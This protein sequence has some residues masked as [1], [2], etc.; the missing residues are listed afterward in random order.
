MAQVTAT[1]L[2]GPRTVFFAS[3]V[4]GTMNVNV[5]LIN[6]IQHRIQTTNLKAGEMTWREIE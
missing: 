3:L 1:G 2:E 4:V 5:I 6:M